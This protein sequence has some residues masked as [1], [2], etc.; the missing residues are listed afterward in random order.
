MLEHQTFDCQRVNAGV[1]FN[2]TE[3]HSRHSVML[4]RKFN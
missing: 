4:K 3:R 1:V 2:R